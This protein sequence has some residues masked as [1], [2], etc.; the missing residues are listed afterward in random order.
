M[1][2]WVPRRNL[3]EAQV[4]IGDVQ[5]PLTGRNINIFPAAGLR[6]AIGYSFL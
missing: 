6:F 3:D 4:V 1:G 2:R 5:N